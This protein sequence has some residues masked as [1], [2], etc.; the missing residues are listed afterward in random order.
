MHTRII[1][2]RG[3]HSFYQENTIE[4]FQK[5]IAL[6]ADGIELDVHFTKDKAL[7]VYHDF[8]MFPVTGVHKPI[9]EYTLDNLKTFSFKN[10][11]TIPT[12]DEVVQ[13]LNEYHLNSTFILNVELKAGSDY[14]PGIE[15]AV[16]KSCQN[17]KSPIEI[18]YSSFDHYALIKLKTLDPKANTG[19][20]TA[21]ALVDPWHYVKGLEADYYHPNYMT[22]NQKILK[23]MILENVLLNPYTV[24]DLHIGRAFIQAQINTII[25]DRLEEMIK[26]RNEVMNEAGC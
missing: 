22:L 14:Y 21:S 24:N 3:E 9:Q 13:L 12:L 19:V 11:E 26:L 10:G 17:I 18:I 2:H 15:E 16:L 25:T 6:N 7:V 8:D 1:A 4:A 20:L 23:E 5:A